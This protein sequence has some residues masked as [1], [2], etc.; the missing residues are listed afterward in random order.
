[1]FSCQ[2]TGQVSSPAEHG[3]V[4]VVINE[5]SGETRRLWSV[6]K[7]A[8][9]PASLVVQ[10]RETSYTNS[11]KDEDDKWQTVTTKGNEIVKELM[12]RA[13]NLPK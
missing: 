6:I 1:M 11:W 7:A 9:K 12:V 4:D 2:L 10:T 3:W 8:E 5:K 13:C